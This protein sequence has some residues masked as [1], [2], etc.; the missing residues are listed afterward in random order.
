MPY[1]VTARAKGLD[2]KTIVY[3]HALKNVLPPLISLLANIFPAI[4]GGSVIIETLF[5]IPGMGNEIVRA[6]LSRNFP[7]LSAIILIS[8]F[9]TI[10]MYALVDIAVY[11]LDPRIKSSAA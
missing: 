2:D 4:I 6:C 10:V 1:I 3:H 9:A 7:L 11:R 8:G 5:S